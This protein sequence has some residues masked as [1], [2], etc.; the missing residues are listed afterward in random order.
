M[1]QSVPPENSIFM[2][3]TQPSVETRQFLTENGH[4]I[5]SAFPRYQP[6]TETGQLQY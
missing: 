6:S 1:A 5:Q 3:V 4:A 2:L